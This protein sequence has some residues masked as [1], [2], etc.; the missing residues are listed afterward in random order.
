MTGPVA[1]PKRDPGRWLV[2]FACI[3]AVL[4]V[5]IDSVILN[6]IVPSI[7]KDF[8]ASQSTIGLMASISTLMLAAFTLGGGTL[9]DLYGRRRFILIGTGGMVAAAILSMLAPSAESLIGIRG[10]DGIFEALVS[11][12]ALAIITVTF[13]SEERPKALS[14]YGAAL[15]IMGGLSS[16][17]AQ[18]LNQAFGWRSTFTLT[19]ALGILTIFLI[20]RFVRES[21]A[22][23]SHKLDGMGWGYCSVQRDCWRWSMASVRLVARAGFSVGRFWF[24]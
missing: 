2:L 4:M 12:L 23:G 5:V 24:P 21:K 20:S 10:L 6:L 1:R 14:I 13:D 9:G 19:I 7:Q 3:A 16:L 15:G 18:S 22:A 8:N 11:P 17:I